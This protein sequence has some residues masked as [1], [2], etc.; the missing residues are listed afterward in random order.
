VE[1]VHVEDVHVEDVHVEDVH[2]EDVHVEDVHVED[3]A[4]AYEAPVAGTD[5]ITIYVV[6]ESAGTAT[7]ELSA[8]VLPRE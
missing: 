5:V 1:D 6:D 3:G 4:L 7:T 8:E 2:V